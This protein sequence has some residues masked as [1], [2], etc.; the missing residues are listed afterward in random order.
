MFLEETESMHTM[1]LYLEVYVPHRICYYYIIKFLRVEPFSMSDPFC[2]LND[3]FYHFYFRAG[4]S[5]QPK[6]G[7]IGVEQPM[8]GFC[9]L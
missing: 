2:F 4:V 1:Y 6:E 5:R 7:H 8:Y 3:C 9:F